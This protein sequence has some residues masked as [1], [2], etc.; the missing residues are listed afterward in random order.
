VNLIIGVFPLQFNHSIVN[1]NGAGTFVQADV[2][3]SCSK[4]TAVLAESGQHFLSKADI[5]S[6]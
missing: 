4:R 6:C 5:N 1:R 2:A 3:K